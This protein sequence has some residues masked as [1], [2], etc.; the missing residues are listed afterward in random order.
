LPIAVDNGLPGAVDAADLSSDGT[1]AVATYRT[2]SSDSIVSVNLTTRATTTLRTDLAVSSLDLAPDDRTLV[3]G[4]TS[5]ATAVL[6]LASG[7]T[8]RSLPAAGSA[9]TVVRVSPDGT[10]VA[11][12][13]AAGVTMLVDFATGRAVGPSLTV[14]TGSVYALAFSPDGRLL[15]IGSSD[16]RATL[17]DAAT[18]HQVV[19]YPADA[20]KTTRASDYDSLGNHDDGVT[21]V[22]PSSVVF[23]PDGRELIVVHVDGRNTAWPIDPDRLMARACA[24]A[25]RQLTAEEW[26]AALPDQPYAD[27]CHESGASP[28]A[29]PPSFSP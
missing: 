2:D 12:G 19:S 3:V 11:I 15:A 25:G 26:A 22:G 24:V 28:A 5:G 29:A 13:S 8:L 6:D 18:G 10:R 14:P 16:G 4:E 20:G 1:T 23:S 7:R 9:V 27:V 17:Y 21:A